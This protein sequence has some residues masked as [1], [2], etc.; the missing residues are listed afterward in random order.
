MIHSSQSTAA[1]RIACFTL[2][3]SLAKPH[4]KRLDARC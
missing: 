4:R 1:V 2:G 3:Y